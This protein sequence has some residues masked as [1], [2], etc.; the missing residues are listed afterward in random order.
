MQIV[1]M[2]ESHLDAI[3][4]IEREVHS[5]P[6]KESLIRQ[7][8]GRCA[9][10][11]SLIYRGEVVGYFYAQHVVGEITLLNLA[12]APLHQGKGLGKALLQFL[13]RYA[14]NLHGESIWLEVRV[15]N[16]AAKAL[17]HSLGFNEIDRRVG[18]YPTADGTEDAIIM[19][20]VLEFQFS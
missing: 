16:I 3:W 7:L 9:I 11:H 14:E 12:I 1:P 8:D 10:H 18:Y 19:N 4:K 5:Y 13:I 17:Y 20:Y 6:W 15:S 2:T